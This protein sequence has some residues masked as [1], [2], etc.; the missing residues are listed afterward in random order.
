MEIWNESNI[1]IFGML[2]CIKK[3]M[4]NYIMCLQIHQKLKENH[5]II[6]LKVAL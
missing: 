2:Y 1:A 6:I 5:R 4:T 3:S